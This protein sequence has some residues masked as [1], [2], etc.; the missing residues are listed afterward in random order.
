MRR[1]PAKPPRSCGAAP[2]EDNPV[3]DGPR[4][5]STV[6]SEQTGVRRP[7]LATASPAFGMARRDPTD[8]VGLMNGSGRRCNDHWRDLH[9]GRDDALL[10][11]LDADLS[12]ESRCREPLVCYVRG[13]T[14]ALEPGQIEP[15]C[16]P[17]ACLPVCRHR[18]KRGQ[19]ISSNFPTSQAPLAK[20]SLGS[21]RRGSSCCKGCPGS[22]PRSSLEARSP[23]GACTV[24]RRF[25]YA[26]CF[27]GCPRTAPKDLPCRTPKEFEE[28]IARALPFPVCPPWGSSWP[29]SSYRRHPLTI[30]R[31]NRHGGLVPAVS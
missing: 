5:A 30:A 20:S 4:K 26:S 22:P 14:R 16:N 6:H 10:L 11:A 7:L 12:D 27:P 23:A 3:C 13:F 24:I 21:R 15:T 25:E 9:S 29:I 1:D 19:A 31:W 28:D 8:G 18:P 2:R 17:A